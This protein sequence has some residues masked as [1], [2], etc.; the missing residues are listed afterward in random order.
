MFFCNKIYYFG[1]IYCTYEQVT[2]AFDLTQVLTTNIFTQIYQSKIYHRLAEFSRLQPSATAMSVANSRR[3]NG[4]AIA[5]I[6][7]IWV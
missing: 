1:G 3:L 2:Y 5:L 6:I 7:P 4:L